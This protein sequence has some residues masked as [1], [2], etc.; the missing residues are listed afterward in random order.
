MELT[1][2]EWA[3]LLWTVTILGYACWKAKPWA[4]LKSTLEILVSKVMLIFLGS[5][6]I[7]VL[8]SVWLLWKTGFWET[9]NLKTTVWWIFGFAAVSLFQ[10]NEAQEEPEHFR[11]I[12]RQLVSVN[13]FVGFI[14]NNYVFSL[15]V[16]LAVVP[17]TTLASMMLVVTDK[18]A[19]AALV[20]KIL[21][22]LLIVVG[23]AL[24][25]NA[26]WLASRQI[27][28]LTSVEAAREFIVPV[29]LSLLYIPFLY[30]WHL[31]LSYE[32]AFGRIRRSIKDER[33]SRLARVRAVIAFNTDLNGLGQWLR[34]IAL[35]RPDNEEDVGSS[36]AEVK[37]LRKRQRHPFRVPPIEGWL[38]EAAAAFLEDE[39][40]AAKEYHRSYESWYASSKRLTLGS[41]T[42]GNNIAYYIEGDELAVRT[43]RLVLNINDP[44]NDA[45]A[46]EAFTGRMSKLLSRAAYGNT[47]ESR[48]IDIPINGTAVKIG[49]LTVRLLKEEYAIQAHGYT[50][51][52]IVQS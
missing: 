18:N 8:G 32:R 27:D 16:E 42:L 2:R 17:I 45:S 23:V 34:H 41:G 50:L 43:L 5:M 19:E 12:W 26:I 38:P 31:F 49:K 48:Q 22:G 11:K 25:G 35:F 21:N 1:N 9:Q 47:G 15:P 29:T 52:L 14:A 10:V 39:S 4:L 46:L 7:Y 13:I 37:R 6:A 33:L 40:L 44:E 20:R 30:C 3:I 28:Y 24:L 51:T 36:I